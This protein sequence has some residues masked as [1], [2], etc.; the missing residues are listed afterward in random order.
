[1]PTAVGSKSS[2]LK[3][4]ERDAQHVYLMV[5]RKT[6][7]K[8]WINREAEVMRSVP[9]PVKNASFAYSVLVVMAGDYPPPRWTTADVYNGRRYSLLYWNRKVIKVLQT[10]EKRRFKLTW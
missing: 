3:G 5:T 2:P 4:N 1:M 10:N 6:L 7:K 8:K 9:W